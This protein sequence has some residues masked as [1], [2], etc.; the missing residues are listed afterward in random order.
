MK[1][2]KIRLSR[3]LKHHRMFLIIGQSTHMHHFDGMDLEETDDDEVNDYVGLE[4]SGSSNYSIIY[5][6]F[7]KVF[8]ILFG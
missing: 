2:N 8:I 5:Q 6:R 1:G 7:Y 4:K 3:L